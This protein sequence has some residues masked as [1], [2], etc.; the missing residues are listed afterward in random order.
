MQQLTSMEHRFFSLV[1]QAVYANPFSDH[2]NRV[3]HEIAGLFP[4]TT[5]EWGFD[6]TIAQVRSHIERLEQEGRATITRYGNKDRE[7]LTSSFLFDLFHRYTGQFD[8]LILDQLQA[9]E[10]SLPVPFAK[11]AIDLLTGWGVD[12]EMAYRYLAMCY[13]LRRAFF[14][15]DKN[16]KGP[17]DSMRRLRESLWNN[18]F[19]HDMDLY[20]RYLWNRMEDFSTM[21]LGE[22]GSGKGTAAMAIGRSGFIPFDPKKG[23]FKESFTRSFIA[24]NLSQYPETLIES[25][26]FGHRKG[27]FT[28]AVE[29]YAGVFDR[30][31]PFGAIFLDEIGEVGEPVQIKL[32]QVI[33]DRIFNRVGD[34]R[35][36]PFRGRL[37][38]ATN[39]PAEQLIHG[40]AM[41]KDFYYRLCSDLIV[42]P[43]LAQRIHENPNE[44]EDLLRI[45][46]ERIVGAPSAELV[47]MV[48]EQIRQ[49]PGIDYAWPGNVRELEQCV[50]RILLKKAYTPLTTRL[51]SDLT[52]AL[53]RGIE[54]QSLDVKALVGGYC[55][56]LF[57]QHKT[58]E[59]VARITGLDRRTAKK[60]IDEGQQRFASEGG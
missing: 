40:R 38:A 47:A 39:L 18:V 20:H 50:R 12:R 21:L 35:A 22:T 27:A 17:S 6:E 4:G 55:L 5:D 15:I 48:S 8:R 13:Q 46:V 10:T 41:R 9:G 29:D 60:N 23:C 7:L 42:V 52:S 1:H 32:L 3:D 19:T 49:A 51:P 26:L 59:A 25:E 36:R 58:I 2:R 24:L 43:P 31:S 33:Q 44:L 30:C 14:F 53:N 16:L 34:H 37:I 45:V 57:R 56:L 54:T 11:S 28:G